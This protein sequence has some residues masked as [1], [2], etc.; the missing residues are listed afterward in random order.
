MV[1]SISQMKFGIDP[2]PLLDKIIN[3]Y[4]HNLP[5]IVNISYDREADVLYV[6][7]SVTKKTIDNEPLDENGLILLGLDD[8]NNISAL[9]IINASEF[10][11]AS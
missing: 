8:Q 7:L 2:F 1:Q 3:E 5:D 11:K 9:T 4:V 6:K 10:V